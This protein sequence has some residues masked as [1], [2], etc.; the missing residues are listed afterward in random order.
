MWSHSYF[1]NWMINIGQSQK[2]VS[3]NEKE[4]LVYCWSLLHTCK[5]MMISLTAIHKLLINL[6]VV[7]QVNI[8]VLN[9]LWWQI[10]TDGVISRLGNHKH[11]FL[12]RLARRGERK[13]FKY[14]GKKSMDM[15]KFRR[16]FECLVTISGFSRQFW[17]R[18]I[19][20]SNWWFS[21]TNEA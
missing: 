8:T 21:V 18:N 6:L 1:N 2:P 12:Q 20:I 3:W 10:C 15:H 5:F 16:C 19:M 14:L 17:I 9:S 11:V 13:Q 7:H 4:L